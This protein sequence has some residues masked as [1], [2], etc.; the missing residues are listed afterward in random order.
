MKNKR[1]L[2]AFIAVL[3]VVVVVAVIAVVGSLTSRD[4]VMEQPPISAV[5]ESESV[6]Y[7]VPE[8]PVSVTM[9]GT[10]KE[11]SLTYS[12]TSICAVFDADIRSLCI[13]A[14]GDYLAALQEAYRILEDA[15]YEYF[16]A[17]TTDAETYELGENHLVFNIYLPGARGRFSIDKEGNTYSTTFRILEDGELETQPEVLEYEDPVTVAYGYK[18]SS[19]PQ[20]VDGY[21]CINT[22]IDLGSYTL[23]DGEQIKELTPGNVLDV[24]RGKYGDDTVLCDTFSYVYNELGDVVNELT[25]DTTATRLQCENY[26]FIITRGSEGAIYTDIYKRN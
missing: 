22:D 11:D 15:G 17:F 18:Q 10:N 7:R 25:I 26:L 8:S 9:E 1:V 6:R 12:D 3:C 24:V 20:P 19:D 13:T 23:F 16:V 2:V 5:D 4:D 21:T 14:F